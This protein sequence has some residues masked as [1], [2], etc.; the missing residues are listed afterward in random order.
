M[1]R[2]VGAGVSL[3]KELAAR[4]LSTRQT[5]PEGGC[6]SEW[7]FL[8]SYIQI[9]NG[10]L[11]WPHENR[12]RSPKLQAKLGVAEEEPDG[13]GQGLSLLFELLAVVILR[14]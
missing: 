6:I 7:M 9:K 2:I 14:T 8:G 13:P 1:G 10:V 11:E 12:N 5:T 3:A 4:K